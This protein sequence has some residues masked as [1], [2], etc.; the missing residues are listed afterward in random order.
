[1]CGGFFRPFSQ[2]SDQLGVSVR[3][4]TTAA[5][6]WCYGVLKPPQLQGSLLLNPTATYGDF[7][8]NTSV[9]SEPS[10]PSVVEKQLLLEL[11]EG[12]RHRTRGD[13]S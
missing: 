8:M 9:F 1:M 5:E 2:A 3:T 12:E 11:P 4:W 13:H 10:P 6:A 7:L